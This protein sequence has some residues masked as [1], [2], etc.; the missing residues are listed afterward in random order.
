VVGDEA[1]VP[2]GDDADQQARP[3]PH[4]DARRSGT[5]RTACPP[6]AACRPGLQVIGW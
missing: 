5:A 2:V 1:H 6:R 4:R 3:D